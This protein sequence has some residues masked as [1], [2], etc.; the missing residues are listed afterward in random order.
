MPF[1]TGLDILYLFQYQKKRLFKFR[2]RGKK[3]H[4]NTMGGST[5]E[6]WKKKKV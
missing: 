4:L 1:I 6:F 5:V 3:G 2:E